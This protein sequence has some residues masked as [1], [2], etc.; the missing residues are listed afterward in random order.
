MKRTKPIEFNII[1]KLAW[2]FHNTTGIE[3]EELKSEATLA[4]ME[5]LQTYKNDKGMKV[6]SWCYRIVK[7]KL[8]D[9]CQAEL[10]NKSIA[11]LYL[12]DVKQDL[13]D[14]FTYDV[15]AREDIEEVLNVLPKIAKDYISIFVEKYDLLCDK[16]PKLIRGEISREMNRQGLKYEY[17]WQSRHEAEKSL[18][19]ICY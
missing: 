17:I 14:T 6:T 5:G 11:G 13:K 10:K 8:I 2:S 15:R 16:K 1:N 12:E 7:Q 19:K 4:Y 3:F 18:T 9:F